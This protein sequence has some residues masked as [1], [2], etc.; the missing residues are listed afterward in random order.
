M[1]VIGGALRRRARCAGRPVGSGLTAGGKST[2]PISSRSR[3]NAIASP[4][5]T[6]STRARLLAAEAPLARS[7]SATGKLKVWRDRRD[8]SNATINLCMRPHRDSRPARMRVAGDFSLASAGVSSGTSRL[9]GRLNVGPAPASLWSC[10]VLR[11]VRIQA[12]IRP[13]VA[14][15]RNVRF[16]RDVSAHAGRDL[17]RV[18]DMGIHL[19]AGHCDFLRL[20]VVWQ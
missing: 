8:S 3:S 6:N 2:R 10:V 11:R 9:T 4:V 5:S 7:S 15:G 19:P 1:S 13:G 20:V 12:G 14:A 16:T 18:G 17:L